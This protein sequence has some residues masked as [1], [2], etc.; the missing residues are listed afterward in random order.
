MFGQP[1][2]ACRPSVC[3]ACCRSVARRRD[4][5]VALS[6]VLMTQWICWNLRPMVTA[7]TRSEPWDATHGRVWIIEKNDSLNCHDSDIM[8][9]VDRMAQF[10]WSTL[11][12]FNTLRRRPGPGQRGCASASE[13]HCLRMPKYICSVQPPALACELCRAVQRQWCLP[14]QCAN[15]HAKSA[16]RYSRGYHTVRCIAAVAKASESTGNQQ[17]TQ[18]KQQGSSKPRGQNSQYEWVSCL[19]QKSSQY[20]KMQQKQSGIQKIFKPDN[21]IS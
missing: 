19:D 17:I 15:L 21:L 2:A 3:S 9:T 1:A 18:K 14:G 4:I 11:Q 8:P 13:P 10:F 6:E 20:L 16:A 5:R 7:E 12:V